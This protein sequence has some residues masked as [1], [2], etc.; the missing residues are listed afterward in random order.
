MLIRNATREDIPAAGAVAAEAYIDDEQDAFMFPGRIKYPERYLKTK[1]SIVRHGMEDPTATVIVVVLEEGDE[2]W[3]GKPDIVGFC[4][5]FREDGD[6]SSEKTEEVEKKALLSRIKSII[7]DSEIYQYTSDL[8][9][10]LVSAQNASIM[11]RTCRL[12]SSNNYFRP[13]IDNLP[14]YGI[15]DI[16]VDPG[17]QG[18][19][20]AGMLVEWGINKAKEEGIPIELSATPAGSG[21]DAFAVVSK[22]SSEQ[23]TAPKDADAI[24]Q[25]LWDAALEKAR[26]SEEDR[27]VSEIIDTFT[28]KAIGD[29]GNEPLGARELATVIKDEMEHEINSQYHDGNTPRFVKKV[30]SALTKFAVLG[31]VAVS[32]DPVHAALPWVAVRLVLMA[33]IPCAHSSVSLTFA[34]TITAGSELREKLLG[35]LARVTSLFLQCN[36]YQR[37]YMNSDPATAALPEDVLNHLKTAIVEAYSSSLRFLGFAVYQQRQNT[38]FAKAPF[39]LGD[40]ANYLGDMDQAGGQLNQA[41]DV[42][43]KLCSF[44]GRATT[45]DV[46]Q[47]VS[48]VR[49]TLQEPP[50]IIY[51]VYQEG[52]LSKLPTAGAAFDHF[53]NQADVACHPNTRVELLKT[54]YE[55]THEPQSPRVFWLQGLAGT[56]KSTISHT[57]ARELKGDAL[58]ASFFFKRGDGDRDNARHLFT[59]IAYQLARKLPLLCKHICDAIENEPRMVE[60]YLSVQ[61]QGLIL[62]PLKKLQDEGF[63]RTLLVVIDALDECEQETHR[64]A[65]IDLLTKSQLR[66]LK[67][68]I[69]SR[70]EFDIRNRFSYANGTYR[71]LVL[72]RVDEHVVEHD[73]RVVLEYHMSKFRREY[74]Q[75]EDGI[76]MSRFLKDA[77][78]FVFASRAMVDRTPLQ[79]Y[80]SALVF[81]PEASLVHPKNGTYIH[82]LY[83]NRGRVLALAVSPDGRLASASSEGTVR[84][85]DPK[86]SECLGTYLVPDTTDIS[87]MAF[88]ASGHY[89]SVVTKEHKGRLI[90]SHT[91]DMVLVY[92]CNL[93]RNSVGDPAVKS[94][95]FSN[96]GK[97][98]ALSRN[99]TIKLCEWETARDTKWR[100]LT[101]P[102]RAISKM[103]FSADG[104]VLYSASYENTVVLWDTATGQCLRTIE[105]P[106]TAITA[107]VCSRDRVAVGSTRGNV[108]ILNLDEGSQTQ[109]LPGHESATG[110]LAFSPDG[111]L[112]ASFANGSSAKIWDLTVPTSETG[113]GHIEPVREIAFAS[114]FKLA[115]SSDLVRK[116]TIW[117]VR[118]GTRK[119]KLTFNGLTA[120]ATA[121][122]ASLLGVGL[123]GQVQIIDLD[124]MSTTHTLATS[125]DWVRSLSFTPD[126]RRLAAAS[127]PREG[128]ETQSAV[129]IWDMKDPDAGHVGILPIDGTGKVDSVALSPDGERVLFV[130]ENIEIVTT[131]ISTDEC[132]TTDFRD[133]SVAGFSSDGRH[134]I[135]GRRRWAGK[136]WDSK[137]GQFLR[138]W[139]DLGFLTHDCCKFQ[140]SFFRVEAAL[141]EPASSLFPR[142]EDHM[143]RYHVSQDGRWLVRDG[144]KVLWL[145]LEY[146]ASCAA[147][148]GSMIVIGSRRGR[149]IVIGLE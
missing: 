27:H 124:T 3:S 39:Q 96:D 135:A 141:S 7:T 127:S 12:P 76:K 87:S 106:C 138:E 1:E 72:H 147:T 75:V 114:N 34:Q 61:F 111:E 81:A 125:F 98:L 134:V 82:T 66:N 32:V 143:S 67:V 60:G 129:Q 53:D 131:N 120:M 122:R 103:D 137:T 109:I 29:S 43:E 65:I 46:L 113:E 52:L 104:N 100:Y 142:G 45:Q 56:G 89:L 26:E 14:Q 16:A 50:K 22:P 144:E 36:M 33:R 11:A 123:R 41:G 62:G 112:L 58:G 99:R 6:K 145:P 102:Q 119:E 59:T 38:R 107:V 18:R 88:S 21:L 116:I 115:V 2:G 128:L 93:R 48:D 117:D 91:C 92:A 63:T 54:I 4:I 97:W 77:R 15:M 28:A 57:V 139:S 90:D 73:I 71:D 140:P 10:P 86:N 132:W 110:S 126:G 133:V 74:N 84:I 83:H 5:W 42:C 19:G 47:L 40:A 13:R 8:L 101:S 95:R 25:E 105:C 85:W 79:L 17:F 23:R 55:W 35:G 64:E 68:F 30:I 136:I 108:A 69:T 37:I 78:R 118:Q 24:F 80:M 130:K 49:K 31:D 149:V 121:E 9:D 148:K 94:E 51:H 70:P 44:Q 146:A 20:I